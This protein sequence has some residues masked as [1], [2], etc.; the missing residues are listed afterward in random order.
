M[1]FNTEAQNQ[2]MG[3]NDIIESDGQ[4]TLLAEGEYDFVVTKLEKT[5]QQATAKIPNGCNKAIITISITT[6]EGNASIKENLL[7][8]KPMEWKL[9]QFFRCIGQ[10]KH[11]EKLAMDW[12]KVE[13]ARGRVKIKVED[14]QKNDGTTG[15]S[16]KVDSFLDPV[17]NPWVG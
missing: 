13:G 8:Y 12:S 1:A 2:S 5:F 17:D 10:K 15:Q 4:F 3:W 9:A 16:N 7:L 14:Y 11:G 6:P